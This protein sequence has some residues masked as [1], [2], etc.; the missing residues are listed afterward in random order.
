MGLVCREHYQLSK[1]NINAKVFDL[2]VDNIK[3]Q[4]TE[5]FYNQEIFDIVSKIYQKD[6]DYFKKNGFNYT[7]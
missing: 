5:N 1:T 3:T 4:F 7:I 2:P 6:L